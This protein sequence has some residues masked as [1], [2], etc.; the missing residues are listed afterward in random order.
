MQ[1]AREMLKA[2][3]IP[4]WMDSELRC[5]YAWSHAVFCVL[6][7]MH[8]MQL[9]IVCAFAAVDGGMQTDIY[10]SCDRTSS[11]LGLKWLSFLA[12]PSEYK[13]CPNTR[14]MAEGIGNAAVVVPFMSEK[15][16]SSTN[17]KLELKFAQQ[18]G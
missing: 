16:E 1:A 7:M 11:S 8:D 3:G 12:F 2:R 6:G 18:V 4:T 13:L 5:I 9:T 14:R 17:C 10:D 15:Y